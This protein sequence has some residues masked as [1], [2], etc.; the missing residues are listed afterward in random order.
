MPAASENPAA[1]I[2]ARKAIIAMVNWISQTDIEA[3]IGAPRVIQLTDDAGLGVVNQTVLTWIIN[4]AQAEVANALSR[5]TIPA[6][7]PYSVLDLTARYAVKRLMERRLQ[8]M[9]EFDKSL[10]SKIEK[11]IDDLRNAKRDLDGL[12]LKTIYR[13][14][15]AAE[16]RCA[17][18]K[19]GLENF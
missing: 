2:F 14:G 5:F 12:T 4:A 19:M 6:T 3:L 9:E 11:D 1:G 8:T 15:G 10:I 16:E 7:I 18:T 13:T 17:E